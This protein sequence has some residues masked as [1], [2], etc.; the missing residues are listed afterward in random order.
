[1]FGSSK[2]ANG[3][4]FSER[5]SMTGLERAKLERAREPIG[6]DDIPPMPLDA[7]YPSSLPTANAATPK[8]GH[9]MPE[10]ARTV[11][12]P[13]SSAHL[14]VGAS[15]R[16]KGEITGCDLMRVEGTFEGTA[17]ARQLVLCPGGSFIGTAQIEEAE[18]EGSFDGTLSVRGRLFLRNKG[19]IRGTFSYGQLEIERGGEVDGKITPFERPAVRPQAEALRLAE[20]VMVKPASAAPAARPATVQAP[21][22]QP[23]APARA[24]A[25][26][27]APRSVAQALN[28]SQ[29]SNR[30]QAPVA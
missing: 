8:R 25:V 10:R 13:D 11:E 29:G 14:Y 24:A 21:P 27:A 17:Q 6:A 19:R 15:I 5:A 20:A 2:N 7:L 18:I 4:G 28:G 23:A 12:E 9:S 30:S 16:L 26:P 22:P 1:M 3:V